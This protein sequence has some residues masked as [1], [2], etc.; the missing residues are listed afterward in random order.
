METLFPKGGGRKVAKNSVIKALMNR[1]GERERPTSGGVI[2]F[3]TIRNGKKKM[4]QQ[5]I[6]RTRKEKRDEP[7]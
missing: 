1:S 6:S 3:R 2:K 5:G 4:C 7:C